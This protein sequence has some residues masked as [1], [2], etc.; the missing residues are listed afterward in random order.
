[1]KVLVSV[2]LLVVVAS[3]TALRGFT[4]PIGTPERRQPASA[5]SVAIDQAFRAAYSLGR[6]PVQIA[7]SERR[8]GRADQLTIVANPNRS[9][10]PSSST[11]T[12]R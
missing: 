7:K 4:N 11:A 12:C 6:V 5:V 1:M 3:T 10:T 8:G 9:P 2:C